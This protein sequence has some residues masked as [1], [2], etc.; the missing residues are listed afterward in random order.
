MILGL[1]EVADEVHA[2]DAFAF[3]F[4]FFALLWYWVTVPC[5][6]RRV[7]RTVLLGHGSGEEP[8]GIKGAMVY[9]GTGTREKHESINLSRLRAFEGR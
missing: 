2:T 7:Q 6:V 1:N 9:G 5:P 4:G 3:S 8:G